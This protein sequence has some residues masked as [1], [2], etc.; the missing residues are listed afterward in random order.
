LTLLVV[1]AAISVP[2]GCGA[3]AGLGSPGRSRTP[4]TS[5]I[6]PPKVAPTNA[7]APGG[8]KYVRLSPSA[9]GPTSC[10]TSRQ[11]LATDTDRSAAQVCLPVGASFDVDTMRPD[12]GLITAVVSSDPTVLACGDPRLTVCRATSAGRS[13]VTVTE[14]DGTWRVQVFTG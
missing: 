9:A 14:A 13:T 4:S 11:H 5:K 6:A 1:G 7:A 12:T 10:L 2:S 8:G 3:T